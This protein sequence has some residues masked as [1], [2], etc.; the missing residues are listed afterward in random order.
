VAWRR[1]GS[2]VALDQCMKGEG[3]K[4]HG[5]GGPVRLVGLA[6]PVMGR[7]GLNGLMGRER[8]KN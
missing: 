5:P 4:G 8:F 3:R 6:G 1:V 7:D 2:A